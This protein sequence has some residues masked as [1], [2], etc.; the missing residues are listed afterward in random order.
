M[1]FFCLTIQMAT[2]PY[3]PWGGEFERDEKA[4]SEEER[5]ERRFCGLGAKRFMG[6]QCSCSS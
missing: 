5:E 4:L 1:V 3:Q 2:N 6:F